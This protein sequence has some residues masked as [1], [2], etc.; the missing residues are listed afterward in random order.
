MLPY[1]CDFYVPYD[2]KHLCL[3]S[4]SMN[5]GENITKEELGTLF[6]EVLDCGPWLMNWHKLS[7]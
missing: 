2:F 5:A 3:N 1:G 4:Q 7:V 6:G